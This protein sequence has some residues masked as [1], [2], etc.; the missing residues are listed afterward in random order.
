VSVRSAAPAGGFWLRL[1]ALTHKEVRQLWRDRSNLASGIALPALLILL[2]GYGITLD[3]T[4][5]PVAV[6]RDDASPV[7]DDALAGLRL[8]PY[9]V[10]RF[11]ASM[12]AAQALMNSRKVD[13]IVRVPGNFTAELAAGRATIQ[14]IVN[15][16]DASS[17]RII[18]GYIAGALG[19]WAAQRRDR[20]AD[21]EPDQ[22]N[23]RIGAVTVQERLW[24]NAANSSTWYLVPGLIVLIMTF[25]GAF[26]TSLLVAREWERG[27][28]EALFVT[29]VR[30]LEILIA[31]LVPYFAVGMIGF[32]M[33]LLA[34]RLLFHVPMAGS[35]GI[36]VLCSC[37]YLLVALGMGLL[38]SSMT[39]NQFLASQAALLISFLP[40][41]MLSGFLFDL[42]NVPVIVRVIGT[43]LP[44]TH[45]LELIKTLLLAGNVWPLILREAAIL[46]GYAVVLLGAATLVTRKRIA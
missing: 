26:L 29:P 27:T 21:T 36:L 44:A 43:A 23:E 1:R 8:S 2:F 6:V 19:Q 9:L 40:A 32:T 28:L 10:P 34:A 7:V 16:P 41:V 4:N 13:A 42:H 30:P 46:V 38:I 12:T 15:G 20:G 17:A 37:L 39:R 33:C 24:F 5:A 3:I 25:V 31:K 35:L 14:V 22:A 45:F 18:A 11:V